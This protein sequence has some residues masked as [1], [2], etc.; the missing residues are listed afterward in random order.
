MRKTALLVAVF[1]LALTAA[2]V[3]SAQETTD[4]PMVHGQEA[5]EVERRSPAAQAS[6]L[7]TWMGRL[8]YFV[9]KLGLA[10]SAG[11]RPLQAFYLHE[12]EEVVEAIERI[13]K[14]DGVEIANLL[15]HKM[16]PPLDALKTEVRTGDGARTDRAYDALLMGCNACHKAA[17]RPYLQIRRPTD[18]PYMQDFAPAP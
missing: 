7:V 3:I 9:H 12:A 14:H 1:A 18:N 8:Q 6:D 13:E 10:V 5:P 4:Q 11:N 16:I 15:R 17:G 2:P